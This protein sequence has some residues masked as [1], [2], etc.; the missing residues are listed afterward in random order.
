MLAGCDAPQLEA[1]VAGLWEAALLVGANLAGA[2]ADAQDE[3]VALLSCLASRC[4]EIDPE[5][6]LGLPPAQRA[7]VCIAARGWPRDVG[8]TA[9]PAAV[10]LLGQLLCMS[11]AA[12]GDCPSN[13]HPQPGNVPP[14]AER[15]EAELGRWLCNAKQVRTA[16]EACA[17]LAEAGVESE[18]ERRAAVPALRER[19]AAARLDEEEKAQLL[20]MIDEAEAEAEARFGDDP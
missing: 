5:D 14:Q 18:K 8:G 13:P 19:V 2:S 12:E 10:G 11:R 9:Q 15:L 4:I 17:A 1:C 16:V 7:A 3:A 20:Q 6:G